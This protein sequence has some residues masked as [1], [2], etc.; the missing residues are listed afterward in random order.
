MADEEDLSVDEPQVDPQQQVN[1]AVALNELA[2]REES[3]LPST[4]PMLFIPI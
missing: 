4:L 3:Q 1:A 2:K